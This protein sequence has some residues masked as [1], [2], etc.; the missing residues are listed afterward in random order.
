M[1]IACPKCNLEVTANHS[2]NDTDLVCDHC[3]HPIDVVE[4]LSFVDDEFTN[5]SQ[6]LE[7]RQPLKINDQLTSDQ[8]T[9]DQPKRKHPEGE[10]LA[11]FRLKKVLGFGGFGFV[12]HAYD[13]KLDRQVAIKI[14]K[15]AVFGERQAKIFI[16]EAQAA[17][18]LQH[19]NIVSVHEIGRAGNQVYIVSELIDGVTL[20]EWTETENPSA[21]QSATVIAKIAR[22]LHAAHSKNIV[23]RDILSLI[24][25]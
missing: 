25:I 11:H 19:P 8:L 14:P 4:L 7:V 15:M 9:R 16:H 21:R 2:L 24:H 12:Y 5:D 10:R 22:A 23:H 1:K 18:Q 20:K 17:A 6:L 13:E 3:K